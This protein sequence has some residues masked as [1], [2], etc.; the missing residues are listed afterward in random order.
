[1][2]PLHDV[3]AVHRCVRV[4]AFR[5]STFPTIAEPNDYQRF[6]KMAGNEYSRPFDKEE[7]TVPCH[8][9][10]ISILLLPP[11]TVRNVK[12]AREAFVVSDK[13]P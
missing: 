1:M 3:V 13:P 9:L 7:Q 2:A 5:T 6:P 8:T 11:S 12:D 4:K 10:M